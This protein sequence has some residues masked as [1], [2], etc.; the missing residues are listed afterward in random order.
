[1]KTSAITIIIIFI[2]I[3]VG[4]CA[5]KTSVPGQ[6]VETYPQHT[7]QHSLDWA[8][9]YT[10]TTPCADCPGIETTLTL[11]YD[12]TLRLASVYQDR[13]VVPFVE[14]G[15]FEWNTDGN[16]IIL[17]NGK[18]N[19]R[20]F[21]VGEN[22]IFILNSDGEK[23]EGNLADMYILNKSQQGMSTQPEDAL[24]KGQWKLTELDGNTIDTTKLTEAPF[25]KFTPKEK[26]INGNAGCNLFFG[27]YEL[28]SD[29]SIHFSQIGATKRF[30][31][32]MSVEDRFLKALN[33]TAGM[34]LQG[35]RLI[36]LNGDEQEMMILENQED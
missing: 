10:G 17:K 13:D 29:S 8:G 6:G 23:I 18:T 27:N 14:E 33:E 34:K 1:M 19:A 4:S 11:N 22:R 35:N 30:C 7:S 12:N 20:Q 15:H 28:N 5:S 26:R 31:P 2:S 25:L 16:T 36:F 32:N 21:R 24:A 9:T 3:F